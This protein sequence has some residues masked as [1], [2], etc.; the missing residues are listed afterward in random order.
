VYNEREL[1]M[2]AVS[3]DEVGEVE[4]FKYLGSFVKEN[5]SFD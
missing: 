1:V 2:M 4:S 3:G 5:G